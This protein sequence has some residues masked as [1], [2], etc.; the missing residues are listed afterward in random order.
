MTV[1]SY[2]G[3]VNFGLG[4]DEVLKVDIEELYEYLE[5]EIEATKKLSN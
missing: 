4:I 1:M 2:C 3:K 5:K